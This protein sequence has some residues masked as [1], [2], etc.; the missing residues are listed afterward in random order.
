MLAIDVLG[1]RGSFGERLNNYME[2]EVGKGK[3]IIG[4]MRYE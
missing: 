3:L 4:T 2:N 1:G